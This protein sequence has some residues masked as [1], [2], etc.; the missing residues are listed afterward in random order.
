MKL[1]LPDY[2]VRDDRKNRFF[3]Y[4]AESI[5]FRR[6]RRCFGFACIA[7]FKGAHIFS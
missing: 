3:A 1:L 2:N 7:A 6:P 4:C 5:A